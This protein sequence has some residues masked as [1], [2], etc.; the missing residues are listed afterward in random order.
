MGHGKPARTNGR[1]SRTFGILAL[2]FDTGGDLFSDAAAPDEK[3][4]TA[5]EDAL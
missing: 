2:S 3:A 5:A 1:F 4:E